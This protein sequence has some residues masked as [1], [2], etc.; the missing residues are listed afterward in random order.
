[1]IGE[2]PVYDQ[3]TFTA[4][5]SKAFDLSVISEERCAI[6]YYAN[7]GIIFEI[8]RFSIMTAMLD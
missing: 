6:Q 8:I 1:M 3:R 5:S 7:D 2:E 4:R